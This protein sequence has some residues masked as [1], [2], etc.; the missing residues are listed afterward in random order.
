DE[1]LR[2]VDGAL[3]V[4]GTRAERVSLLGAGDD[5]LGL[6]SGPAGRLGGLSGLAAVAEAAR[7]EGL[8][9]EVTLRRA[10]AL[11]LDGQHDRAAELATSVRARAAEAGDRKHELAACLELGQDL[12]RVA[13]GEGYAPTPTEADLDGAAEAYEL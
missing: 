9:L 6:V 1:A 7:E 12:L 4:I 3:P 2:L 11:R 5:A 13:I 8:E 10:A